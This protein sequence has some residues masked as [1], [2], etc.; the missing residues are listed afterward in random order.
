LPA[1][2]LS[3]QVPSTQ[4]FDPHSLSLPQVAPLGFLPIVQAWS[5]LQ[6]FGAAQVVV[7]TGSI[8]PVGIGL[9]VPSVP[10]TPH[11]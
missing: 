10:G 11:E 9:Q 8:P 5:L 2:A 1:Q 4:K 7:A 3:Q 6:K